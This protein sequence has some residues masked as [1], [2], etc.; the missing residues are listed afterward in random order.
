[1]M[2]PHGFGMPTARGRPPAKT[3]VRRHPP[4][5][6]RGRP[7]SARGRG[8]IRGG[9]SSAHTRGRS[10]GRPVATRGATRGATK[11]TR[12]RSTALRRTAPRARM[13]VKT[14]VQ[15]PVRPTPTIKSLPAPFC[16]PADEIAYI[17]R[18][19]RAHTDD[20]TIV[21]VLSAA[22]KDP[23]AWRLDF[24][25]ACHAH[26]H[27]HPAADVGEAGPAAPT[28]QDRLTAHA[29][30]LQ[31][32]CDYT[33]YAKAE[34]PADGRASA[35]S[36]AKA[37]ATQ[38]QSVHLLDPIVPTRWPTFYNA[39]RACQHEAP[40]D[41][42]KDRAHLLKAVAER[43]PTADP[44]PAP[45]LALLHYY[46]APHSAASF[47]Q[48]NTAMRAAGVAPK[49]VSFLRAPVRQTYLTQTLHVLTHVLTQPAG[50]EAIALSVLLP[51]TLADAAEVTHCAAGLFNRI[52]VG[53]W[54][55]YAHKSIAHK[56]GI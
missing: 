13:L 47:K 10:V 50:Q 11:T 23:T 32:L 38:S 17:E 49:S 42:L 4:A 16:T 37:K 24:M 14:P 3:V 15:T 31:T 22:K 44:S 19:I 51:Y 48:L 18:S 28:P 54:N 41:P 34:T 21:A 8:I 33:M 1:M 12:G 39:W 56:K 45:T 46:L 36:K 52:A 30:Y 29:S 53:L 26:F 27:P 40:C 6:V 35:S 55:A 25:H 20:E 7:A 9:I 5:A 43:L 2:A